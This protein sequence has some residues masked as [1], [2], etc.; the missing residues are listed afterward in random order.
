MPLLVVEDL[1]CVRARRVLFSNLALRIDAGECVELRGPNGSG[2]TT[3]LRTLAGLLPDSAQLGPRPALAY[4]GHA[5]GLAGPLTPLEN[6]RWYL[7]IGGQPADV[8]RVHAALARLGISSLA[9]RPTERLSA[10]QQRRVALARLV[11]DAA[12]LWLLD[13]PYTALDS[14]GVASVD[15]LLRDHCAAGGAALVAS[16]N[17]V[18]VATRVFQLQAQ[19]ARSC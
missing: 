2:K 11:L 1:T 7:G 18:G 17:P 3:L 14:G 8:Q 16:H 6:L 5:N 9:R 4:L 15:D 19:D 10:G 12:P 13:E